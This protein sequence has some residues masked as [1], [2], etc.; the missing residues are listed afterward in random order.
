[1]VFFKNNDQCVLNLSLLA[2]AMAGVLFTRV[3]RAL[4][5]NSYNHRTYPQCTVTLSSFYSLI[6]TETV[7]SG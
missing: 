7:I 1:M 2:K 5:K 6:I 4:P 3:H